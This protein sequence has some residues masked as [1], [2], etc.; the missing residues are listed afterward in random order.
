MEK[1]LDQFDALNACLVK[2]GILTEV[3]VEIELHRQRFERMCRSSCWL[4][5]HDA[6]LCRA[7]HLGGFCG[8]VLSFLGRDILGL[9]LA[10]TDALAKFHTPTCFVLGGVVQG[11]VASS[12]MQ[13]NP[14]EQTWSVSPN[15]M[16][17]KAFNHTAVVLNGRIYAC[18]V[19]VEELAGRVMTFDPQVDHKRAW[20]VL[21]GSR[22]PHFARSHPAATVLKGKLYLCGG[23]GV[24]TE[25]G[26]AFNVV[27]RLDP[28]GS[29]TWEQLSPMEESRI[30]AACAPFA[31]QVLVCGGHSGGD[32]WYHSIK[33]S[34]ELYDP[35]SEKW[36]PAPSMLARREAHCAAIVGTR[37]YV[38]GGWGGESFPHALSLV[39]FLGP[40]STEWHATA[41]MNHPRGGVKSVVIG[42]KVFVFGGVAMHPLFFKRASLWFEVC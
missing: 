12:I 9:S 24:G 10:C 17:F 21:T 23:V 3:D 29:G 28:K 11:G 31:A 22:G 15:K 40:P 37:V 20:K 36:A 38:C 41:P 25:D 32:P 19:G 16:P 18:G 35:A 5:D 34:A 14:R 8:S 33:D 42:R 27:E 2:S 30:S 13:F 6:T 39:E 1:L 4:P 26:C 7:F